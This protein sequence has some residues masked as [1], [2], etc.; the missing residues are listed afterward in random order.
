[1]TPLE[2]KIQSIIDKMHSIFHD[3]VGP[4]DRAEYMRE[5]NITGGIDWSFSLSADDIINQKIPPRVA[6]CTGRA[7][8]FCKLAAAVDLPCYVV[9]T[10][11]YEDWLR[12][13]SGR[14][15]IINGHQIIAVEIDGALR[16]FSPGRERLE[17]ISGD[18]IPGHFI[19]AV[20]NK[21]KNLI[22][23]VVPGDVFAKCD[24]YQKLRNLYTSG[25]MDCAD[26]TITP[27][28]TDIA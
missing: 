12:A 21:P 5:N 20:R 1:M 10:A 11:N 9:A 3:A 4:N 8:V 27:N 2:S 14:P 18:V 28:T 16:A 25:A 7:K 15:N 19:T 26:F 24:T 22:T 6:G 17:W 13:E 23:A